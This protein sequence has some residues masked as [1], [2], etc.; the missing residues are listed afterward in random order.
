M[1]LSG[2]LYLLIKCYITGSCGI[3]QEEYGGGGLM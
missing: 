3:M 1:R 2:L